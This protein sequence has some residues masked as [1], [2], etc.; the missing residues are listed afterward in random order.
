MGMRGKGEG[1][2]THADRVLTFDLDSLS[3]ATLHRIKGQQMGGRGDAAF[4]F[5][6][7]YDFESIV[8]AG[9]LVRTMGSAQSGSKGQAPDSTHSVYT[10]FH[11]QISIVA[12]IFMASFIK[13]IDCKIMTVL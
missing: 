11:C 1:A 3:P 5:V 12:R 8:T 13:Q 6:E 7:V 2:L 9:I 10:D 4:D